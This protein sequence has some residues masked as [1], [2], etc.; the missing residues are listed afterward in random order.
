MFSTGCM[1]LSAQYSLYN[2]RCRLKLLDYKQHRLSGRVTTPLFHHYGSSSWHSNDASLIKK[3]D[4]SLKIVFNYKEL[5][6]IVLFTFITF[7]ILFYRKKIRT[8]IIENKEEVL[9][10]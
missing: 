1:Y 3:V 7:L 2:D 5:V 8:K 4:K 9:L 6:L 10:S